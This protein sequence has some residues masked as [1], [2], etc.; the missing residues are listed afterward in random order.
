M[1]A[2]LGGVC[3]GASGTAT[4]A[5][6]VVWVLAVGVQALELSSTSPV[7][8]VGLPMALFAAGG[9]GTAGGGRTLLVM[10]VTGTTTAVA[11]AMIDVPLLALAAG[12][13]L[14]GARA[15][16]GCWWDMVRPRVDAPIGRG[17]RAL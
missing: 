11:T 16:L 3:D 13:V 4:G 1:A 14:T 2:G 8:L 5:A 17:F 12:V 9:A 7:S 6:V 10:V 15:M